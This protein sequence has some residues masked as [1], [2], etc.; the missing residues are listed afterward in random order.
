MLVNLTELQSF[1]ELCNVSRH[2]VSDF[3]RP[4]VAV[5]KKIRRGRL[6]NKILSSERR[7]TQSTNALK[8][9]LMLIPVLSSKHAIGHITLDIEAFTVH[10]EWVLSQQQKDGTSIVICYFSRSFTEAERK[11][12]AT[13]QKLLGIVCAALLVH[14]NTE[15]I[16]FTIKTD[17]DSLMW[18]LNLTQSTSRLAR[19]NLQLSEFVFDVV[20]ID[21]IK[22]QA[23]DALSHLLTI[24]KGKT[25]PEDDL[26]LLAIDT[27][28]NLGNTHHSMI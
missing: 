13:Q 1:V 25:P 2:F 6:A 4:A 5:N 27:M 12:D 20:Y 11:K 10:V 26:M 15:G 28:H 7:K 16:R 14:S 9:S 18:I 8:E 24:G 19:W 23:A 21:G 3:A 17:H 22:H